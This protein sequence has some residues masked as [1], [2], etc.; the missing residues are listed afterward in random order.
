M[1]SLTALFWLVFVVVFLMAATGRKRSD[2]K[3]VVCGLL[4][5]LA[6]VGLIA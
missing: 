3:V 1:I 4:I 2:A 5:A 6:C